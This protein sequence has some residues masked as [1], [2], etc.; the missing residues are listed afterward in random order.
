M[1]NTVH[2]TVKC[3][4]CGEARQVSHPTATTID[5]GWCLPYDAFGFYGGFT[6]NLDFLMSDTEPKSWNMCHACIVKLLDTF[7]LLA[8]S[9][10]KGEHPS[11]YE[12][13][14]CCDYAWCIAPSGKTMLASG[15]QWIVAD[16]SDQ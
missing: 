10:A 11:P 5:S 2:S 1:T 14:P 6:D 3:D 12:D 9:L 15:G 13:T 16:P 4:A 7:P 8:K